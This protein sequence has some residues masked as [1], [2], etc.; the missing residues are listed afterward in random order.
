[1]KSRWLG[2]LISLLLVFS[3][4]P[5][6]AL[7]IVGYN[8]QASVNN[9]QVSISGGNPS[10]GAKDI[11]LRVVDS[12]SR[13]V[14][15]DQVRA[16]GNG[17]YLF[18]P[19]SLNNGVYTAFVGGVDNPESKEFTI[20]SQQPPVQL[21]SDATLK[22]IQ[23]NSGVLSFSANQ[24]NY[25][26]SVGNSVSSLTITATPNDTRSNVV[27]NNVAVTS[28]EISLDVGSNT[29]SILVTAQDNTQ[30]T[31][32]L[33]VKRAAAQTVNSSTPV[34]ITTEPVSITVPQG[35]TDAK[36]EVPHNT[37]G[38]NVQATV[39]LIETKATTSIG[40]ISVSI[41]SGTTITA[42][43]GWDGTIK[44]PEVQ[45]T[46]SVTASNSGTVNA[47]VEVGSPTVRL[48]FNK[49]VRLLIPGQA[50]KSAAYVRD[51]VFT[52]ITNTLSA[53]N[54]AT[55]DAEISADSEA[56]IAVGSDLVIWTKH[57]T[58]FA[59]YTPTVA[60]SGG[61]GGGGGSVS[62]TTTDTKVSATNGGTVSQNGVSIIFPS[63]VLTSD[64]KVSVNKLSE[65]SNLPVDSSLKLAS[66]VFEL[67]KDVAGDFSKPV[68]VTL[69]FDNTKVDLT[70]ETLGIYWFNEN[71]QKWVPLENPQVDTVNKKVTGSVNHFTKFAVLA[72]AKV[73]DS[74]PVPNNQGLTDIKGHWAENS[75]NEL[76]Q[77]GAINGY[78]D[79]TFKPDNKITRAEFA[80]LIVRAF[81]LSQ[82]GDKVFDDTANHWA[83]NVIA[84][85]AAQGIIVGYDANTFGPDDSITREQ[86]AAMI[87]RAAKLQMSSEG[88][89]FSDSSEISEWA[90]VVVDTA[91]TN[92][93]MSGYEDG[94]FKP[95]GNAT[96]AEAVTVILKA[97]KK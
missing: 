96:R 13:N 94:S 52:P 22:S 6:Y 80:S 14:L 4:V 64:F 25:E 11:T 12:S 61:G 56:K 89:Q 74:K 70:K 1:M 59:S 38:N 92:G 39:P 16:D 91:T 51:G 93:L 24:L 60:S 37:V 83:K 90:K 44:L 3:S 73:D 15:V 71:T 67:K 85:A 76:I 66:D 72:T 84:T 18:G 29:A 10:Y 35:V 53:D 36:I 45:S 31:Y 47:V 17:A 78:P 63:A 20:S 26:I 55:A 8:I 97:L 41:P 54:Q 79:G 65:V 48:T 81:K 68:S 69:P 32:T 33:T 7:T 87:V 75:I 82:Q 28:K 30:K 77:L 46:S 40:E 49:A 88:K 57:F 27:I 42:P 23:L 2:L 43:A 95:N 50:G 86:M 62:S 21:S 34:Q 9:S 58:K 5:A 19:Y